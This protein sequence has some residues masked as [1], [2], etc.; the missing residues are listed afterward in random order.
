MNIVIRCCVGVVA[1]RKKDQKEEDLIASLWWSSWV[2][3][4]LKSWKKKASSHILGTTPRFPLR[5]FRIVSSLARSKKLHRKLQHVI[6]TTFMDLFLL[7]LFERRFVPM[8]DEKC[9]LLWLVNVSVLG[10]L[11][12]IIRHVMKPKMTNISSGLDDIFPSRVSYIWL[13]WEEATNREFNEKKYSISL[14][15]NWKVEGNF[16][17]CVVRCF[18]SMIFK[19]LSFPSCVVYLCEEARVNLWEKVSSGTW[20]RHTI[21]QTNEP[22]QQIRNLRFCRFSFFSEGFDEFFACDAW[23]NT[24]LLFVFC[25]GKNDFEINLITKFFAVA[26]E[27]VAKAAA[28]A[29]VGHHQTSGRF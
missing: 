12:S 13:K 21:R 4:L 3:L 9:F 22:W 8:N 6:H 16:F 20:N 29:D 23:E 10:L 27:K 15:E 18:V 26:G 14:W 17:C 25:R 1:S 7:F 19:F 2:E 24:F 28:T 5:F 11:M